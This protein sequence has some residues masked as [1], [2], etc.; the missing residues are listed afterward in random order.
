M[1]YMHVVIINIY[2]LCNFCLQTAVWIK[3]VKMSTIVHY[4]VHISTIYMFICVCIVFVRMS[5]LLFILCIL[6]NMRVNRSIH[7]ARPAICWATSDAAQAVLCTL[8]HASSFTTWVQSRVIVMVLKV[9]GSMPCIVWNIDNVQN[10][11]LWHHVDN[12][13]SRVI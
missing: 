11:T 2:I 10:T 12:A 9:N 7:L 3:S 5:F 8:A 13:G 4:I 6:C 1:Y